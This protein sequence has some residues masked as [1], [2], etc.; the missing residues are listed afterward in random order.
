[1]I[2]IVII[3]YSYTYLLGRNYLVLDILSFIIGTALGQLASYTVL[4]AKPLG[5]QITSA[6]LI[7][8]SILIFLFSFFTFY[9]PRLPIFKNRPDGTYGAYHFK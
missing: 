8:L 7:V 4:T 1:M 5:K 3:F 2:F 9:P 6:S